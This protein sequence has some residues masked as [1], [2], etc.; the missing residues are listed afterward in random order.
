MGKVQPGP[1]KE[2]LVEEDN[3]HNF[4]GMTYTLR[5]AL[6]KGD[7]A[8]GEDTYTLSGNSQAAIDIEKTLAMGVESAGKA[9]NK[10][11]KIET[12]VPAWQG[13]LS[14]MGMAGERQGNAFSGRL[15]EKVGTV[16]E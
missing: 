12:P 6:Q 16:G 1:G 13:N 4:A 5:A 11:G 10:T 2:T 8:G 7:L 15:G 9:G 14:T 3:L